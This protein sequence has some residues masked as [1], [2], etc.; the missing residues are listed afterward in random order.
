MIPIS[1]YVPYSVIKCSIL[2]VSEKYIVNSSFSAPFHQLSEEYPY[3]S[4]M[5][6]AEYGPLIT[7]R[8]TKRKRNTTRY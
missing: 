4:E 1:E 7:I 6:N 3:L 5:R 8:D 2:H